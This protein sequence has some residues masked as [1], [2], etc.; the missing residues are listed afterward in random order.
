MEQKPCRQPGY[1]LEVLD[2]EVLLFNPAREQILYCNETAWLI[3]QLCDGERTG[4]EI[5]ALLVA[6]Y[7]EAAEAIPGDVKATL[8]EFARHGAIRLE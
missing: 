7:P 2:G 1:Q 4:D 8:I 6:A 3:W 5:I